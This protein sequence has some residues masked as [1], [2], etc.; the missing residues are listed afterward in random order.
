MSEATH[1]SPDTDPKAPNYFVRRAAVLGVSALALLGVGKLAG[2]M[3]GYT[4]DRLTG[5]DVPSAQD[6]QEHPSDFVPRVIQP[7]DQNLTHIASEYTKDPHMVGNNVANFADQ[8]G[9]SSQAMTGNTLMVPP[10]TIDPAERT[11][12]P[13]T[14]APE[15]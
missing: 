2:N 14:Q 4:H 9:G 7:E 13:T 10:T 3:V 15:N 12:P 1:T 8:Q 5:T 6:V 11:S